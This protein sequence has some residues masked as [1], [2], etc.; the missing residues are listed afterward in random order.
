MSWERGEPVLY[1]G[2]KA[3]AWLAVWRDGKNMRCY[4]KIPIGS[5][6]HAETYCQLNLGH[7]GKHSIEAVPGEVR[8]PATSDG[9]RCSQPAGH[10]GNHSV[11]VGAV[12]EKSW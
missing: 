4:E 6:G 9:R 1:L 2:E 8:C 3:V 5:S 11:V 10:F 12:I 7:P